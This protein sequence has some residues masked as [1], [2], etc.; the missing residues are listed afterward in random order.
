MNRERDRNY[1]LVAQGL[2]LVD[3][4]PARLVAEY[5][6]RRAV[7]CGTRSLEEHSYLR[8]GNRPSDNAAFYYCPICLSI[9]SV[10]T[11]VTAVEQVFIDHAVIVICSN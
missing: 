9:Y 1:N 4:G 2:G 8:M 7:A 3:R 5:Y 10:V 6:C 11:K